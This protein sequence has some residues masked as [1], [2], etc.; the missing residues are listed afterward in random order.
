MPAGSQEHR[1]EPGKAPEEEGKRQKHSQSPVLPR[2]RAVPGC[3]RWWGRG[4]APRKPLA[5][6][7]PRCGCPNASL[8]SALPPRTAEGERQ[9]LR[10][11]SLQEETAEH[12]VSRQGIPI[13]FKAE[14]FPFSD[15]LNNSCFCPPAT[16]PGMPTKQEPLL[17]LRFAR[18]PSQERARHGSPRRPRS[19]AAR[20]PAQRR[21]NNYFISAE[22]DFCY[23]CF[24]LRLPEPPGLCAI[25]T[26]ADS[27]LILWP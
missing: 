21:R 2:A 19:A 26:L 11:P 6:V 14:K 10:S 15:L 18:T 9:R 17:S 25:A 1:R 4:S 16:H 24:A 13:R 12:P 23:L 27:I 5:G 22:W 8:R 3:V 7:R 20:S